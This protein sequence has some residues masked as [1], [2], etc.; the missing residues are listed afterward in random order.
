[1][2]NHPRKAMA[3]EANGVIGGGRAGDR[4]PV[5]RRAWGLLLALAAAGCGDKEVTIDKPD[6]LP[7]LQQKQDFTAEYVGR[8]SDVIEEVSGNA[9]VY[10]V[11]DIDVAVGIPVIGGNPATKKNYWAFGF[12]KK[13]DGTLLLVGPD[14]ANP[15]DPV[16]PFHGKPRGAGDSKD[17]DEIVAGSYHCS[18]TAAAMVLAYWAAEKGKP[19]LVPAGGNAALLRGLAEALDTNDQ[20]ATKNHGDL[21]VHWGTFGRDQIAGV[22]E[23]ARANGGYAFTLTERAFAFDRYKTSIGASEPV[24]IA[25]RNPG[26][27]IGHVV[28]GYGYK[29]TKLLYKDP[30]DGRK[31]E[32]ESASVTTTRDVNG[33]L[34]RAYGQFPPLPI[35]P[36]AASGTWV[37]ALMFEQA[38]SP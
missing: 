22:A 37:D 25:F 13:R 24:I 21:H 11:V 14:P 9:F 7:A 12:E 5:G 4:R 16:R 18:P 10:D 32:V 38:P 30:A 29:G 20:N 1:M 27:K 26:S 15:D 35:V 23:Y 36:S 6:S 28:V 33:A 19:A 17:W 34:A 3:I 8:K 2:S 31:G